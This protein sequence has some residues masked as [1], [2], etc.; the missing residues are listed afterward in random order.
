MLRQA[1]VEPPR[2]ANGRM[3]R[4]TAALHFGDGF[5]FKEGGGAGFHSELRIYKEQSEASVMIANSSEIDVKKLLSSV[6]GMM[7]GHASS[8]P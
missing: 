5:L 4:M 1:L 6:D 8:V 7:F 3:I 2:F